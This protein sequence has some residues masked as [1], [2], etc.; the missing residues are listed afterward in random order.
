MSFRTTDFESSNNPR[1][2]SS[3]CNYEHKEARKVTK[4]HGGP[5]QMPDLGQFSE[6]RDSLRQQVIEGLSN[7]I[8]QAMVVGD[9]QLAAIAYEALGRLLESAETK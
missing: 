1:T 9:Q 5:R 2:A 6:P 4:R 3:S 7:I 8:A